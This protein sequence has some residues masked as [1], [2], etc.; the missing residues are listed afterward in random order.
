MKKTEIIKDI[1]LDREPLPEQAS[2]ID[3]LK[4]NIAYYEDENAREKCNLRLADQRAESSRIRLLDN[5]RNL[6]NT[7]HEVLQ[8]ER[9][10]HEEESK[11]HSAL[12]NMDFNNDHIKDYQKELYALE[13]KEKEIK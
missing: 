2:V 3:C 1:T 9:K 12:D 5:Y 13:A 8:E 6:T 10:L 11:K 7:Y 4:K